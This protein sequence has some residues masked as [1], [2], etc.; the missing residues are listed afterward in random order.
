MRIAVP[1]LGNKG[2]SM[3]E[4]CRD[5]YFN[6]RYLVIDTKTGNILKG[7]DTLEEAQLAYPNAV[8]GEDFDDAG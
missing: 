3:L 2:V 6:R 7:Y 5:M 4:I 1:L 8:I